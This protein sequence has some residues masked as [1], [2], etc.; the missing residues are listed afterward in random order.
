MN[1]PS[2]QGPSGISPT[3]VEETVSVQ[4]V[5]YSAYLPGNREI[6]PFGDGHTYTISNAPTM[7]VVITV[8]VTTICHNGTTSVLL[9]DKQAFFHFDYEAV[10]RQAI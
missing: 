7:F 6:D 9:V 3:P 10:F 2:P 8:L 5:L 1:Q 4:L